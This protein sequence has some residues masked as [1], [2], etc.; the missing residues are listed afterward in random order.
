[1]LNRPWYVVA[2]LATLYVVSY[3]DRLILTLLVEPIQADMPVSDVQIGLLIGPAFAI[4]FAVVG[5]P[6]AW[7][8]DR[9]NRVRLLVAGVLIWS[10]CTAGAGFS[11]SF[12]QLFVFRMGLAV[13]EAVLSPVGISL[14][15]DMF[16]QGRRS[17]PSAV[18]I[19]SGVTGV[20]LAYLVGGFIID[21]A[22]AGALRWLP[23]I[24]DEATWRIALMMVGAPGLILAFVI[25]L[26]VREPSRSG[27]GPGAV[28]EHSDRTDRYGIFSS[29]AQAIRYYASFFAGNTIL[30]LTLYGSLAWYPTY[31]IRRHG[32]SASQAGYVF[33]TALALG[34]LL[35]LAIPI[36]AER[37]AV[38]GRR[39]LIL[40]L[41]L[42]I[43]P[44]GA[45][46]FAASLMQASLWGATASLALGFSLLSS[47]NALPSITIP[48]TAPAHLRGRLVAVIQLCNNAGSLSI[49]SFLVP[50]LADQLFS[51]SAALG[52]ALLLLAAVT[53]PFAWLL[54]FS[55]WVPYRRAV[56][57]RVASEP[58]EPN[59][60]LCNR[61]G[62]G[63]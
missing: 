30:G 21:L 11:R 40:F 8:V 24:G 22:N 15:G 23:V 37:I 1:M 57:A 51:G 45:A 26:T 42:L 60:T 27:D 3:V 52:S 48:Q 18:F 63:P 56:Y 25:L 13:G 41:P 7:M 33:S 47:V 34:V 58:E 38:K 55:A 28:P 62:A 39:D 19:A 14:I 54:F 29:R 10:A 36:L 4:L 20:M 44:V 9:G 31:L 17:A 59:I 2:L 32:I 16:A 35:T 61:S 50:A 43:L 6:V 5:I 53:L 49:G 46:F 12:E